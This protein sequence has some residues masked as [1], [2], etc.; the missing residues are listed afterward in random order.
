M[1]YCVRLNTTPAR[2]RRRCTI[3]SRSP[4]NGWSSSVRAFSG[5]ASYG[6]GVGGIGAL[7][8]GREAGTVWAPA[9]GPAADPLS[10][11]AGCDGEQ[12]DTAT[13]RRAVWRR[14]TDLLMT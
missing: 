5:S 7:S 11:D 2:I 6:D 8:S 10:P 4:V 13:A 9:D 3:A 1:K 12:L 14:V